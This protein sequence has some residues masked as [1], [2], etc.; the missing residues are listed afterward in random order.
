MNIKPF[1]D[2]ICRLQFNVIIT[3]NAKYNITFN[4]EGEHKSER[5]YYRRSYT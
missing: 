4:K 5:S 1:M 2:E 3:T